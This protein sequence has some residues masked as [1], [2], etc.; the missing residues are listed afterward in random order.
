MQ[1]LNPDKGKPG[2]QT[3]AST[4]AGRPGPTPGG[5]PHRCGVVVVAVVMVMRRATREAACTCA[6]KG[7][8]RGRGGAG[9]PGMGEGFRVSCVGV[10]VLAH[11]VGRRV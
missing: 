2:N 5:G 10:G 6:G 4:V 1:T 7:F 9:P 11:L 3:T 8:M